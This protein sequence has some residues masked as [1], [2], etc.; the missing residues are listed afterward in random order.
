MNK[1]KI[2][3]GFI[4]GTFVSLYIL[5]SVVSTIHV[6]DFFELSNPYWLA[7]T[8]AIGF[9]LGAAAS[10]AALIT[11]DKMNKSLV[12]ALFI[13]ITAMQMQGNMYYAF[14]SLEEYTGWV[15]LFNL[16]EWEPLAQKRLLA[17]VSGAILPLVALGFIKS[18]VDYIKPESEV[19][20]LST[21][22][23]EE[24]TEDI[25]DS[26]K[27]TDIAS[28]HA[29]VE[30]IIESDNY[31]EPSDALKK[32]A[33]AMAKELKDWDSTIGDGLDELEN[34]F[35]P[36][37]HEPVKKVGLTQQVKEARV[38]KPANIT[39]S[40]QPDNGLSALVQRTSKTQP[41]EN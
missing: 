18:L 41:G 27:K 25:N 24:A 34:E 30:A 4:I 1:S 26:E 39:R 16:V 3:N 6:I 33:G 36:A 40:T 32:A 10:L 20:E 21:T 8:L 14:I 19:G 23:L 5:V 2:I 35:R 17:A 37:K 38:V 29:F 15:E 13:T 28:D 11:L 31:Q 7:V 12:W 9:E 22:N